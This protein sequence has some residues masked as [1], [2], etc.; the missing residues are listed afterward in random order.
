M[1]TAQ[2]V[3]YTAWLDLLRSTADSRR[4]NR[5]VM[6]SSPSHAAEDAAMFEEFAD[7]VE[8][9]ITSLK[10]DLENAKRTL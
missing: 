9:V 5:T 1:L 8:A 3:K 7:M 2:I 10:E 6:L 4:D